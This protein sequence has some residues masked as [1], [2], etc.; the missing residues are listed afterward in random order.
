MRSAKQLRKEN[1]AKAAALAA[2][3]CLKPQLHIVVLGSALGDSEFFPVQTLN[4]ASAFYLRF[5]EGNNLGARDAG[6]CEIV[7]GTK[8]VARVSYNGRVWEG[9]VYVSGAKPLFDPLQPAHGS[10]THRNITPVS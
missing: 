9:D 8:T 4:Q 5:I 3:F 2:Q 7:D 1:P 10:C 6:S